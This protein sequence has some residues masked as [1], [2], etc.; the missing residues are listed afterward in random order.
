MR[1]SKA[2]T[3]IW[4]RWPTACTLR[5]FSPRDGVEGVFAAQD[6]TAFDLLTGNDPAYVFFRSVV[7]NYNRMIA[8]RYSEVSGR[9]DL[10]MKDYMKAQMEAFPDR[11]FFPD[12]NMTLRA[13]YGQVRGMQARDGLAY[14]PQ[15]FLDGGDREIRPGRPG[16]RPA[17]K[18]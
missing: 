6:T 4:R 14:L 8:P 15:T 1:P 13:S 16:I 10:L 11:A 2:S 12:A 9:I 3:A 5:R 18:N 17:R 7:E